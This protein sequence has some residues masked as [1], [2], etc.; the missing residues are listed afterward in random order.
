MK[1]CCIK[2]KRIK[3]N[4]A[5]QTGAFS[6]DIDEI[7]NQSDIEWIERSQLE[8][9]PTYKQLIPYAIIKKENYIACY[10][11]HG[12]ENRLHGLYSCGIGG[13]IDFSDKRKTLDETITTGLLRE[14]SEELENFDNTK[15]TI[16]YCGII[17][18]E[19]TEIGNTHLGLVYLITCHSDYTPLP[20]SELKGLNW[21]ESKNLK[22]IQTE[23]WTRLALK[24]L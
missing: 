8:M 18:E 23:L 5:T 17:N 22:N 9:D 19:K 24:F 16:T 14:L 15:M 10:P 11:R 2:T 1:I 3:K 6:W 7:I 12:K 21:I 4:L 13:H 20:A